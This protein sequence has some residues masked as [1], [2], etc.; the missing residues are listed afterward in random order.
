[1]NPVDFCNAPITVANENTLAKISTKKLNCLFIGRVPNE[2]D[3]PMIKIKGERWFT[4]SVPDLDKN[5]GNRHFQID[6]N[7]VEQMEK[8]QGLFD[9]VVIDLFTTKFFNTSA[10]L[11]I[12]HAV[13]QRGTLIFPSEFQFISMDP[14][15]ESPQHFG[16]L[17]VGKEPMMIYMRA[18]KQHCLD[19]LKAENILVS[20]DLKDIKSIVEAHAEVFY[21][22]PNFKI[23]KEKHKPAP[24]KW[25]KNS[26]IIKYVYSTASSFG[27]HSPIYE[28]EKEQSR[29]ETKLAL[30]KLFDEVHI[31]YENPFP[32]TN[33]YDNQ[34]KDATI[35]FIAMDRNSSIDSL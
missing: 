27:I 9:K 35:H 12:S 20:E 1:M 16:S 22:N 24:C 7:N 2:P 26:D 6:C 15:L 5:Y 14:P 10:L 3:L 13:K 34:G 23:W 33:R 31:I 8:I 30:Q 11:S 29:C 25:Q 28:K 19:L 4:L 18:I 32:Y 21:N 17:R